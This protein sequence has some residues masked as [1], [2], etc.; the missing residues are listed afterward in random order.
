MSEKLWDGRFSEETDKLVEAFTSSIEVDRRLYAYDIEGSIAHCKMLAKTAIIPEADAQILVSGLLKIKADI[1]KGDFSYDDSLEDIHMHIESRLARDVGK[2]AQKLHTARSRNDQ[3]ALD[4]RM[5]LRKETEEVIRFLIGLRHSIVEVAESQIHVIMPGYTHLQRAQPVLLSHHLMAYY[6]MLKRDT[7][8][9]RDSLKRTDVMPLG[10]AALAGTTYPIDREY[11]AELLNFPKVSANS[12]DSVSDRDFIIEFLSASSICMVHLSRMAEELILWSSAEFDFIE[13]P[14]AFAT[15]SSIM[16]QKK[17][18]DVAELIRGK[19]GH[20][21]GNLISLLTMMKSLPLAYNR[22]MQ[23]DKKPLF[24]TVDTVKACLRIYINLLPKLG[25]KIETLRRASNSGYL[26]ATDLADYLVSKGMSFREAHGCVGRAVSH[27]IAESKEL[28]EL[29]LDVLKTFSERIEGDVFS[30]LTPEAM[31][32]RRLSAGGTATSL[33]RD[34]IKTAGTE[35][36]KESEA[37]T[38]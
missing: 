27:A 33:V 2:A 17:N 38:N 4:I 12:I 6:E 37:L 32:N 13:L 1:E 5:Y 9:F 19:S 8:R 3:V 34:A 29:D 15:G 18:P 23:E 28:H 11:T 24:E 26:N 22:D 35:L 25:I 14:D 36:I 30:I 16:P 20:V 7:E 31:V 21:F 10:S